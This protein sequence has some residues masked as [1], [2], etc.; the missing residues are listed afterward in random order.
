[1]WRV[2]GNLLRRICG[3]KIIFVTIPWHYLTFS[4]SFSHKRTAAFFRDYM[5]CNITMDWMWKQIWESTCL[6]SNQTL[7]QFEKCKSKCHFYIDF[8]LILENI[9]IFHKNML[10]RLSNEFINVI[11]EWMNEWIS[12]ISCFWFLI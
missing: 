11:F 7:K 8:F 9:D 3:T 5:V 1:M 2:F 10:L 4:G 6:I 12:Y